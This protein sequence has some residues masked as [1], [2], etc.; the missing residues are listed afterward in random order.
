MEALRQIITA[1]DMMTKPIYM[2]PLYRNT[3][4]CLFLNECLLYPR[5]SIDK[6]AFKTTTACSYHLLQY[7]LVVLVIILVTM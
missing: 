4:H 3:I 7:H 2:G 6:V 5:L 1:R